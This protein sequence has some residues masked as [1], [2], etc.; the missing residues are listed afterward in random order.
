MKAGIVEARRAT[1]EAARELE[2]EYR[3]RTH[4]PED[5]SMPPV[6]GEAPQRNRLP[7]DADEDAASAL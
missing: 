5:T 7:G 4:R 6:I 1:A 2:A 3:A